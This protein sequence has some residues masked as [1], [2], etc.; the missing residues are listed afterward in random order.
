MARC[1]VPYVPEDV[2]KL[3]QFCER[4]RD[5]LW[6]SGKAACVIGISRLLESA[7]DDINDLATREGWL[8]QG[9]RSNHYI[10]TR[11]YIAREFVAVDLKRSWPL[12]EDEF[13]KEERN[14]HNP[15]FRVS[16]L[17][18]LGKEPLTEGKRRTLT[19]LVSS[20]AFRPLWTAE[21]NSHCREAARSINTHAGH[22]LVTAN[23]L[24]L[25]RS[26]DKATTH[27]PTVLSRIR[28]LSRSTNY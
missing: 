14:T 15:D 17:R 22:K 7:R 6:W 26:A 11:G 18:S 9:I 4:T 16:I 23:D 19:T 20:K 21:R 24:Q 1:T 27:L 25:L 2:P 28:N 3:K 5:Q 10:F 8:H 13:F 12:L